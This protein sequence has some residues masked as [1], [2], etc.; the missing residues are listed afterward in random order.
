[1]RQSAA[2][3]DARGLGQ[4]QAAADA[5]EEARRLLD[6]NQESQLS[7]S[8]DDVANRAQQ[9][10]NRQRAI[11][12]AVADLPME[13]GARQ[14]GIPDIIEEKEALREEIQRLDQDLRQISRQ[15]ASEDVE[16][17]R[18]F[19]DAAAAIRDGQLDDRIEYSEDLIPSPSMAERAAEFEQQISE[20]VEEMNA[21]VQQ[22]ARALDG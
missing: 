5:L 14:Q 22:G 8:V 2:A 10:V 4:A 7:Q 6:R 13:A 19:R 16:A 3:R 21:Q 18:A 15:S 11:E 12:Q 1:M 17:E 20:L 9:A